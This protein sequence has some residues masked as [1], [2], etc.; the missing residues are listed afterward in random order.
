MKF[1][2]LTGLFV[3]IVMVTSET[4]SIARILDDF[5]DSD[6]RRW[7]SFNFGRGS[8]FEDGGTLTLDISSEHLQHTLVAVVYEAELFT[9]AAEPLEMKVDLVV[10]TNPEAF[11]GIAWIPA[12]LDISTGQGYFFVAS[13]KEIRIGK[14]DGLLFR[15]M[16]PAAVL[17]RRNIT[18]SL[19]LQTVDEG[20][21]VSVRIQDLA[22]GA[23]LFE[24]TVTD[25]TAAD[26]MEG[27]IE[28]SPAP[29]QGEGRMAILQLVEASSEG[30]NQIVCDNAQVSTAEPAGNTPPW[31][32]PLRPKWG[33]SFLTHNENQPE[34][35]TSSHFI[36]DDSPGDLQGAVKGARYAIAHDRGPDGRSIIIDSVI[37]FMPNRQQT[38]QFQA[39][40]SQRLTNTRSTPFDTF[41][42]SNIVI[43]IEDYDF[44]SGQHLQSP[45]PYPEG[46]GLDE[47][48]YIGRTGQSGFDYKSSKAGESVYRPLDQVETVHC[49][50]HVRPLQRERGSLDSNVYDYAVQNRLLGDYQQYTREF[51]PGLYEVYL[52]QR[53]IRAERAECALQSVQTDGT[54]S[55]LGFFHGERSGFAFVNVPLVG[56]DGVAKTIRLSGKTVLRVLETSRTGDGDADVQRNYL[57]FIRHPL[58]SLVLQSASTVTGPYADVDEANYDSGLPGFV[59][60]MSSGQSRFYRIRGEANSSIQRLRI[61]GENVVI[62]LAP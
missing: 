27:G 13:E 45:K 43:E 35:W 31:I 6:L 2:K 23:V 61:I 1:P 42:I 59:V 7:S 37:P 52:R 5:E 36:G 18:I 9:V 38:L 19:A 33:E 44:E 48:S 20:T 15:R 62:Q 39:F 40:D 34:F 53:I 56:A 54:V 22:T 28:S 11:M 55:T 58:P 25:T 10:S 26:E 3:V 47:D 30:T 50:D 57:V 17:P 41:S 21:V 16:V 46:S 12:S 60:P 8:L 24:E 14:A 4:L 32:I 51:E 29:F 49:W